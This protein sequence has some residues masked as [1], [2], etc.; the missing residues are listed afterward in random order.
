MYVF[1][2]LANHSRIIKELAKIG[3]QKVNFQYENTGAAVFTL[4]NL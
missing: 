1:A 3:V 2:E 4:N